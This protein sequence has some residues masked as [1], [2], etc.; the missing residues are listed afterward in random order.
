M[1]HNQNSTMDFRP[2]LLENHVFVRTEQLLEIG[3]LSSE[4]EV[5]TFDIELQARLHK[6]T[7]CADM[8]DVLLIYS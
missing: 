4:G 7:V 5:Y 8:N 1:I 2:C 3:V 6:D